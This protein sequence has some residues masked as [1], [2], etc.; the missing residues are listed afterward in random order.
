MSSQK[1]K[2]CTDSCSWIDPI[3]DPKPKPKVPEWWDN[4]DY[5]EEEED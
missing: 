3:I 4:S 1:K 5:E 2:L